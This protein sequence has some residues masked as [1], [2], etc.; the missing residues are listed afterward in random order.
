M[1][2]NTLRWDQ[3]AGLVVLLQRSG[4]DIAL[5]AAGV[6]APGTLAV[7]AASVLTGFTRKRDEP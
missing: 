4:A 2:Y 1:T 7:L 6:M 5:A 3:T